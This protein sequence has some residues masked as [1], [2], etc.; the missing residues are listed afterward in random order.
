[1]YNSAA[2]GKRMGIDPYI[3]SPSREQEAVS[4]AANGEPWAR[5]TWWKVPVPQWT[6]SLLFLSFL[7]LSADLLHYHC[8]PP[9]VH[10]PQVRNHWSMYLIISVRVLFMLG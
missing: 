10:R 7:K 2:G 1:M 4:A 3:K 5:I 9:G 8:R 6:R